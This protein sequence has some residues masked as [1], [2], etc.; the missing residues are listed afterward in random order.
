[1]SIPYER[2]DNFL[3]QEVEEEKSEDRKLMDRLVCEISRGRTGSSSKRR[4]RRRARAGSSWTGQSLS[5]V[6]VCGCG[7]TLL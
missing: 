5:F 7:K 3:I 6:Y 4:R 2:K 1:M